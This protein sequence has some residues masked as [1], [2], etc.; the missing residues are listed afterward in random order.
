MSRGETLPGAVF[1]THL[2]AGLDNRLT[3]GRWRR[4]AGESGYF[5]TFLDGIT[6]KADHIL[7]TELLFVRCVLGVTGAY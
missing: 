1:P 4:W 2:P 7:L 6:E 3:K 5:V